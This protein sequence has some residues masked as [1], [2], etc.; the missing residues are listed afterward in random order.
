MFS[1]TVDIK[2]RM[3]VAVCYGIIMAVDSNWKLGG[4][5]HSY[6]LVL[7][8]NKTDMTCLCHELIAGMYDVCSWF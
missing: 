1:N 2:H 8:C 6:D 3:E 5:K 7:L 4:L